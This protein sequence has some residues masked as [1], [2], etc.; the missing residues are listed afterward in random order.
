MASFFVFTYTGFFIALLW[1]FHSLVKKSGGAPLYEERGF[2][3]GIA[4]FLGMLTFFLQRMF[5]FDFRRDGQ[6]LLSLRTLPV[7]PLALSL[8]EIAVPTTLCIAAQACGVVPLIILGKFDWPTLAFVVLGYPAISLA[9]NSVWNIHYLLAAAK[10][11]QGAGSSSSAVGMVMVVALSFLVFYPA[12][13]TTIKVAN[14]FVAQTQSLALA[15]AAVAGLAVQYG[16]DLLLILTMAK[17]FNTF[18]IARD[19]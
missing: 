1:I 3:S 19:S 2:T 11:T 7:S 5:P 6:H 9:L 12:G 16:V 17:L 15:L 14:H 13:W 10:R 4:L 8:A 18:E